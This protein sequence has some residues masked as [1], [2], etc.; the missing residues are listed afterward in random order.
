MLRIRIRMK[1]MV[2]VALFAIG[3]SV[4]HAQLKDYPIQPVD[5]TQVHVHDHFWTPKMELNVNVTI[6][7]VLERCYSTGRIENF[8]KAAKKLPTDKLTTFPFDDTDIYKVIEGASY[9]L[10]VKDDPALERHLDTL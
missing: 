4:A 8:L 9:A 7:Y 6:P 3:I 5:F 2:S 1:I 10:E